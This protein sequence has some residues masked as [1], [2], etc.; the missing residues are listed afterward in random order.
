VAPRVRQ[1]DVRWCRIQAEGVD[2]AIQN[3]GLFRREA[4]SEEANL[5]R[6]SLQWL[7]PVT[8]VVASSAILAF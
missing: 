5:A 1:R 2:T 6:L 7:I 4:D 8:K 3:W